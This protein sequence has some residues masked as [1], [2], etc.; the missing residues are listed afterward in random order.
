M[1]EVLA[2]RLQFTELMF[3]TSTL[4][5]CQS[6]WYSGGTIGELND[7]QKSDLWTMYSLNDFNADNFKDFVKSRL[8]QQYENSIRVSTP[9]AVLE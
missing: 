2:K 7:H 9:E 3:K 8:R 4:E 5:A 1:N 6:I